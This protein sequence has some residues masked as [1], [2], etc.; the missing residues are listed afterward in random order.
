[1]NKIDPTV[2]KRKILKKNE[3]VRENV[4]FRE[5]KLTYIVKEE[6]FK[7]EM[8]MRY[9]AVDVKFA[10]SFVN[11]KTNAASVSRSNAHLLER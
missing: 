1:M 4:L 11:L 7:S 6:M 9:Y 8:T 3:W 5:A 2:F 10:D